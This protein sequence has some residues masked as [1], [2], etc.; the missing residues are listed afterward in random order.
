MSYLVLARKWRPRLFS[1]MVG[2]EHVV[3][4]LVNAIANNR[5]HHAYLFA[6]TRGV[7]K[8]T[9]GR[10][11]AKAVNCEA[12]LN[13]E[14]CGQCSTC[15]EI[16]EGRYVDLLEVDAASRTKVEQTR[17]LL[18]N[19]PYSPVR[20]RFKVYLIDEVHMFSG[21]SFNALLKTL[22]EPPEHV[23]FLLATTDPQKLPVTVLSRCLQFHLKRL[24]FEQIHSQL[25][26][27]I[28]AEGLTAEPQA[29]KRLARA[30][31]GS[32]RDAL[33]LLDQGIVYGGGQVLES[34]VVSMLGGLT[35]DQIAG[36][37]NALID[38]DGRGVLRT[39]ATI[40]EYGVDFSL[41]LQE[42]LSLLHRVAVFQA[43][44]ESLEYLEGDTELL[45]SAASRL[46]PEDIQLYYQ[47][48]LVG[49][50]DLPLAPDPRSGLEMVVLRMLAF[51]PEPSSM[52]SDSEPLPVFQP[53]ALPVKSTPASPSGQAAQSQTRIQPTPPTPVPQPSQAVS[54]AGA[55][56]PPAAATASKLELRGPGSWRRFVSS[57]RLG[58]V[59]TQLA[60]NCELVSWDGRSLE[61]RLDPASQHLR[62]ASAEKRLFEAMREA[63]GAEV[64]IQLK[65]EVP[66]SETPAQTNRRLG[67]ERQRSA[68]ESIAR[69]P[70]VQEL[71][72]T[73]GAKILPGSLKPLGP[74]PEQDS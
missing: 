21:H 40:D 54:P 31:D 58:G 71:T 63:L 18:E 48:G 1:Q 32:M 29:L 14:P 16:D 7:G 36:L 28:K 24:S 35:Q 5:M 13:P 33:S 6:G 25:Q 51:R 12:G 43:V 23:K 45:R 15:R 38:R 60:N 50:R 30:A 61:L 66:Q 4:P 39:I 41:V 67:E 53:P 52:E 2:Q 46:T 11:F 44:P 62:V 49:Q 65:V 55:P 27:I 20:G 34:D 19:V 42:L 22:E 70:V 64:K 72:R 8:T 57:L 69:D 59:A 26:H 73:F 37:F 10:I 9:L 74:D 68:E 56:E 47:I 17:E 3:R